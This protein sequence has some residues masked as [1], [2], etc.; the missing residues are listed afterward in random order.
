LKL[1]D[2]HCFCHSVHGVIVQRITQG[3]GHKVLMSQ[4]ARLRMVSC[5]DK[6]LGDVLVSTL[7]RTFNSPFRIEEPEVTRYI[8]QTY[9]LDLVVRS[10]SR[11][12]DIEQT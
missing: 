12:M 3:D 11:E 6:R 4:Y 7:V 8:R 2:L 5:N 9:Q 10:K 1:D